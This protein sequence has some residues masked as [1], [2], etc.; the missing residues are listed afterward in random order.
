MAER[1]LRNRTV[2]ACE[3]AESDD[4]LDEVDVEVEIANNEGA[5]AVQKLST[6]QEGDIPGNVKLLLDIVSSFKADVATARETLNSNFKTQ[7]TKLAKDITSCL[8]SQLT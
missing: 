2:P 6:R 5:T 4:E 7:N 3:V 8:T 1:N